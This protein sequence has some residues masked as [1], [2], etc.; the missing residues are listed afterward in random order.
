MYV[1]QNEFVV[2]NKFLQHRFYVLMI[3]FI[4]LILY[5]TKMYLCYIVI[6][7]KNAINSLWY[8]KFV[9]NLCHSKGRFNSQKTK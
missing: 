9:C 3:H 7:F 1:T 8:F 2:K 6:I 4:D 5:I